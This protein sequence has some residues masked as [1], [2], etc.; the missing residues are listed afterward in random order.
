M[1]DNSIQPKS[2]LQSWE[3]DGGEPA[4]HITLLQLPYAED[5]LEPVI[6]AHTISFHYGKHHAG[7]VAALN[8]LIEGTAYADFPL[9]E[10]I[11][12][13]ADSS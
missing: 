12:T 3:T 6:S 13:S 4:G 10:I 8:K 2:E 11:V 9:E 1:E 5:A 7:Y